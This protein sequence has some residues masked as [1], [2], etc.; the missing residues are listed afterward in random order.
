MILDK[1]LGTKISFV[2][3]LC[4]LILILLKFIPFLCTHACSS[5]CALES[6]AVSGVQQQCHHFFL[7]S[8]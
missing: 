1:I 5:L 2:C 8:K 7:G 4:S 6:D 3:I